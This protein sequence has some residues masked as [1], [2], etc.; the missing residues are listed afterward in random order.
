[1]IRTNT[2]ATAAD[3]TLQWRS[4]F[5][6]DAYINAFVRTQRMIAQQPR[7]GDVHIH[8]STT[9]IDF[10]HH[11]CNNHCVLVVLLLRLIK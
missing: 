4:N 2:Y 5:N 11:F 10:A 8:H 1:M 9:W 3:G 7:Q 6:N